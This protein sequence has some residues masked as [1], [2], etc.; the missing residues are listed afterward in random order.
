VHSDSAITNIRWSGTA[1]TVHDAEFVL[2]VTRNE[3]TNACGCLNNAV[4]PVFLGFT[5]VGLADLETTGTSV[6]SV[7]VELTSIHI[8][9][10]QEARAST[11]RICIPNLASLLGSAF[12]L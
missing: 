11:Q 6:A 12:A 5:T 1:A 9:A 8:A 3:I 4:K 7:E 2:P 10:R